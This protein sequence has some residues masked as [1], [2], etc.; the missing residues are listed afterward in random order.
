MRRLR[1][2]GSGRVEIEEVDKPN[3]A[4]NH[5]LVRILA[6]AVCGSER[7]TLIAGGDRNSGHEASGVI[8]ELSGPAPFHVGDLVGLGAVTGCG[9]CDRCRQGR[10]TQCRNGPHVS[11]GWH[12]EYAEVPIAALRTVDTPDPTLATLAAGDALGVPARVGRRFPPRP[13]EVVAVVGLGPVGLGHVLVQSFLG[14]RVI[15]IEPSPARRAEA[16]RLG[17]TEVYEPGAYTEAPSTVI[18]CTGVPGVVEAA[19]E[20]VDSS[21]R[22]IQSG[23]CNRPI[24]LVPSTVV[25]HKEVAYVGSWF[26]AGE[27]LP[28]MSE[29]INRGL[30]LR[31]LC[32]DEVPASEAQSA[33]SRFLDGQTGKVVITW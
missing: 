18:E 31:A 24:S 27:D 19:F 4:P 8:E 6:S 23:E 9:D 30:D 33:I 25:V 2:V 7:G 11:S 28:Y 26:Y 17:A 12:A 29:L 15:G 16:L 21:G 3:A 14:A 13:D 5:A 20:L 1:C 32:T 10:E 22:V